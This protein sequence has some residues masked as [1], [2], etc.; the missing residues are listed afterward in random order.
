MSTVPGISHNDNDDFIVQTKRSMHEMTRSHRQYPTQ[1]QKTHRDEARDRKRLPILRIRLEFKGQFH[2]RGL[3]GAVT[4][5]VKIETATAD[6]G[7]NG[8]TVFLLDQS[9]D[10]VAV[11]CML[12]VFGVAVVTRNAQLHWGTA[13]EVCFICRRIIRTKKKMMMMM[14]K[15]K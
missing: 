13:G 12:F 10:T 5:A 7:F 8:P 9:A 1:Q 15:K 3:R 4:I 11:V 6:F 2:A 14:K